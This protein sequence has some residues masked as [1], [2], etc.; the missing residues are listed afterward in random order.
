MSIGIG[1]LIIILLLIIVLFGKYPNIS[2]D[3]LNGIKNIREL[4]KNPNQ[5]EDTKQITAKK[6]DDEKKN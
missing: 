3:I 4:I 5:N 2:N 6:V 1:Q